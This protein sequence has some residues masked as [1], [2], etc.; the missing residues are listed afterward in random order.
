MFM[1]A[2][3]QI[4]SWGERWNVPFNEA[5]PSWMEH[6]IFHLMKIFVRMRNIHYL[7]YITC[8]KVQIPKQ[9]SFKRKSIEKRF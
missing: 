6:F 9:N 1:S 5:K 4:F 8:S 2:M 7:F 3:V